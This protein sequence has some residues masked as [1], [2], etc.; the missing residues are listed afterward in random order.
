M[1]GGRLDGGRSCKEV[2]YREGEQPP[3]PLTGEKIY[4]VTTEEGSGVPLYPSS[5][6]S[7]AMVVAATALLHGSRM[8]RSLQGSGVLNLMAQ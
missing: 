3:A 7:H 4:R 5:P 6:P 1:Q 2:V 8:R